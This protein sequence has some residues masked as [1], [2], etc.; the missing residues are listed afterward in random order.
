MWH[1][2]D[3]WLEPYELLQQL[4]EKRLLPMTPA[5]RVFLRT[6]GSRAGGG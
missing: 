5:V 2:L 4:A 1:E 3:E 6:L